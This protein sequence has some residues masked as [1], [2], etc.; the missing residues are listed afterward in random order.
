MKAAKNGPVFASGSFSFAGLEDKYFAAVFL[1]KGNGSLDVGTFSDMAPALNNPID[2]PQIGVAVGGAA[3]NRFTVFTGPKDLDL[4]RTLDP[5]LSQ[6]VDFGWFSLHCQAAVSGAPMGPRPLGEQLRLGDCHPHDRDQLPAVP[7]EANQL[8]VDEEDAGAAAA[9]RRNQRQ[10]QERRPARSAKS[11]AEPGGHGS[12]QEARRQS[13]G[14]LHA[15]GL[16]DSI[17]HR[18]LQS[19]GSGDRTAPRPVVVGYGSFAARAPGHPDTS[20]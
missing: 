2:A 3:D 4:L 9:D 19:V 11:R 14:R 16:A 5:R 15:D 10:V 1:P 8:E 18:L 17:L 7:P 6:M 13:D 12:L 20:R